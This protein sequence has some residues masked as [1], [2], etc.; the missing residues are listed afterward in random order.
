MFMVLSFALVFISGF[1]NYSTLPETVWGFKCYGWFPSCD[2]DVCVDLNATA[3]DGLQNVA[4][5]QFCE[6]ENT[7][8]KVM[9]KVCIYDEELYR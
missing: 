8:N 5:Y 9:G 7:I 4:R 6:L 1:I 2:L 3:T